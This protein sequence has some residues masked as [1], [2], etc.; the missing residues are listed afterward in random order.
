M[1]VL[2]LKYL[3]CGINNCLI[4]VLPQWDSNYQEIVQLY[5]GQHC[6]VSNNCYVFVF[7]TFKYNIKKPGF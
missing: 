2:H 4:V 1:A 3:D 7:Q 5:V 6:L